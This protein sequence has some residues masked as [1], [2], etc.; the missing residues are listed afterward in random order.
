M[1]TSD[2]PSEKYWELLAEERRNALVAT[3]EENEQVGNLIAFCRKCLELKWTG[4]LCHRLRT[5]YWDN[6]VP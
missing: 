5:A 1:I 6:T 3:L 2:Q 4:T